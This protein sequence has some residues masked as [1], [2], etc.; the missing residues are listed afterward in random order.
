MVGRVTSLSETRNKEAHDLHQ[1]ETHHLVMSAIVGGALTAGGFVLA[2]QKKNPAPTV[3]PCPSSSP[4]STPS[5]SPSATPTAT[6]NQPAPKS[7]SQQIIDAAT[8]FAYAI[9]N[10]RIDKITIGKQQGAFAVVG[11]ASGPGG[12]TQ[13]LKK[14]SKGPWVVIW[15][16]NGDISQDII[17]QFGVP[18]NIANPG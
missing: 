2:G 15:S 18:Q 3:S 16:G 14:S 13:V 10:V 8:A 5:P 11:V 9:D 4:S 6:A 7:E 1:S 17:Q 12:Y